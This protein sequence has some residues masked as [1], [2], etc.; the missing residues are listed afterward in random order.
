[1]TVINKDAFLSKN[2]KPK[3]LAIVMTG[4]GARAAYQV[5]VL[6]AI[7]EMQPADSKSPFSIICGTSAGAINAA[8]L[9]TKTDNFR[10]SVRRMDFVWSNFTSK[11]IFRTNPFYILKVSVGLLFTII[12]GSLGQHTSI[13]LLDRAPLR[14]LLEKFIDILSCTL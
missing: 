2:K 4:G 10:N 14:K 9:A 1:M 6:K 3:K 13:Y 8:A 12:L 5:G 7:S 11:Q